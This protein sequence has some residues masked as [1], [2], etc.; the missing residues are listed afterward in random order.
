MEFEIVYS[1]F[2]GLFCNILLLY[3]VFLYAIPVERI[4]RLLEEINTDFAANYYWV[5]DSVSI[6]SGNEI[7]REIHYKIFRTQNKK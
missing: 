2:P 7:F 4:Y 1:D 6:E 3:V 5:C